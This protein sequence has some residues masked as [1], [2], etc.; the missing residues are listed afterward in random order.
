MNPLVRDL[1]RALDKLAPGQGRIARRNA[2]AKVTRLL[3]RIRDEVDEE[4]PADRKP[5]KPRREMTR[6]QLIGMGW[7]EV[8]WGITVSALLRLAAAGIR[9]RRLVSGAEFLPKWALIPGISTSSLKKAKRD[10][11]FRKAMIAKYKLS[12]EGTE[13]EMPF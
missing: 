10:I 6:N 9:P 2:R 4:F 8:P 5:S 13:A 1:D 11:Q 12:Q 7:T 3:K